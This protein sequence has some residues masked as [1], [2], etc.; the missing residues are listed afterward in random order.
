MMERWGSGKP[1]RGSWKAKQAV[2]DGAKREQGANRKS[3]P[4]ETAGFG[5][6]PL[7]PARRLQLLLAAAM[8]FDR[9][10]DESHYRRRTPVGN[11][12]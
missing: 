4:M 9:L 3:E 5:R 2:S 10:M 11:G 8:L 1:W 12:V 7:A 6:Q